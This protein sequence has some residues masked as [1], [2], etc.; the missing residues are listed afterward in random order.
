MIPYKL[1]KENTL[2]Y[3]CMHMIEGEEKEQEKKRGHVGKEHN[4]NQ[5]S[6]LLVPQVPFLY[7]H[8]HLHNILD[9]APALGGYSGLG[10]QS[11]AAS[12][13][14]LSPSS[15]LHLRCHSLH[16]SHQHPCPGPLTTLQ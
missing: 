2:V 4:S 8:S 10:L 3:I 12:P 5:H 9:L 7:L 11:L 6:C 13:G 1:L 16:P 14:S 15:L